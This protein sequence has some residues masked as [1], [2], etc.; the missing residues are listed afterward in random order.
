MAYVITGSNQK[1]GVAKT[2]TTQNTGAGLALLGYKT[3]MIDTDP[4]ANLTSVSV[5]EKPKYSLYNAMKKEVE[6]K[7][8]I[9]N[10]KENLDIIPSCSLM[11]GLEGELPQMG[12][13]HRLKEIIEPILNIYD[14]ILIDTAPSLS[15]ITLN[16]FTAS[17][18][19][20]IPSHASKFSV[21]GISEVYNTIQGVKLYTNPNLKI[22]GILI[23]QL[24]AK[25]NAAK[26]VQEFTTELAETIDVSVFETKI[27]KATAINDSQ[28]E[29]LDIYEHKQESDV[30][31]DYLTFT[32]ELVD[33]IKELQSE[34]NK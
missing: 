22:A 24:E 9:V 1:G 16:A 13:Q 34:G 27:R 33:K 30:A 29:D 21:Q 25:T 20:F 23:T 14:Y 11:A 4:Q 18:F 19:V 12:K 3:L 15:T 31:I 6:L 17:D 26:I 28:I 5:S 7:D 10:V 32:T 8:V 2:T